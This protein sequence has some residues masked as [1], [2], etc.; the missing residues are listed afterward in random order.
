MASLP[1]DISISGAPHDLSYFLQGGGGAAAAGSSFDQQLRQAHRPPDEAR[2]TD[3]AENRENARPRQDEPPAAERSTDSPPPASSQ[4]NSRAAAPERDAAD[5][6]QTAK[7]PDDESNEETP[8]QV[9][10]GDVVP[11]AGPAATDAVAVVPEVVQTVE[12]AAAAGLEISQCGPPAHGPEDVP[13]LQAKTA[14][15]TEA[16]PAIAAGFAEAVEQAAAETSEANAEEPTAA[17]EGEE[18]GSQPAAAADAKARLAAADA[19]SPAVEASQAISTTGEDRPAIEQSPEQAAVGAATSNAADPNAR[20]DTPSNR[21]GKKNPAD[22]AVSPAGALPV[23]AAD[24]LTSPSTSDAANQASPET[25]VAAP[26][27]DKGAHKSTPSPTGEQTIRPVLAADAGGANQAAKSIVAQLGTRWPSA[28]GGTDQVDRARFV[29]RVARA[30]QAAED[31]GGQ[32]RLRLNPPEL[33]ALRMEL[34]VRDGI[35]TARLEAETPQA[36]NMLLENLPALRERMQEQNIKIERFDVDLM[37][38]SSG[39]LPQNT[40]RDAT[41]EAERQT[42]LRASNN[43]K[44]EEATP[45]EPARAGVSRGVSRLDVVI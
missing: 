45:R 31:G 14:S 20:G 32:I 34:T 4:E 23:A 16:G 1:L 37:N 27:D 6:G 42:N 12:G 24:P 35:M 2:S 10:G 38:Q 3:G 29:Q 15:A 21:G 36:R 44:V 26:Q 13:T 40:R 33:G 25:S 18:P 5:E 30:F 19:T 7:E 41:E 17:S 11:T 9:T 39:G 43:N 28:E 8:E 22:A